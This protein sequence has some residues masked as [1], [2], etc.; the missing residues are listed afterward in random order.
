VD[1]VV[2][3]MGTAGSISGLSR[4][5]KEKNPA[6][7]VIGFEPASSP[8]YSGGSQAKHR[9]IGIG[10]GFVT[11][12]FERAR[13]RIDE[14]LLVNDNDAFEWTA[15]IARTEGLLVGVTSGAAAFAACAVARR[16]EFAGKTVVTLFYD[17]GE[18][19]LSTPGL[20]E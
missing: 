18:R 16:P 1:A 5:F 9:L 12:N 13:D 6:I 15:R 7:R 10:P 3:G 19:Y 20:F 8:V 14:I 2:T 11:P 4:F 17:T